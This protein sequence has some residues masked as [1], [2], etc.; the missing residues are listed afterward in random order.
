VDLRLE[1]MLLASDEKDGRRTLQELDVTGLT[2][3][4]T[5]EGRKAID[6]E[7][8]SSDRQ[9]RRDWDRL[10]FELAVGDLDLEAIEAAR[11]PEP[12]V[13]SMGDL[14]DQAKSLGI[15]VPPPR[16]GTADWFRND[17]LNLLNNR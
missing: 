2:L 16:P 14:R 4:P 8:R 11:E 12:T 6:T 7:R 3:D 5:P 17:M 10:R 15:P 1:Y 13:P 9:Q